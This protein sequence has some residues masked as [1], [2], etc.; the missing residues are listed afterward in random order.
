MPHSFQFQ[1][2]S[3]NTKHS[4]ASKATVANPGQTNRGLDFSVGNGNTKLTHQSEGQG[5]SLPLP[6][7]SGRGNGPV[8]MC[9][10]G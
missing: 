3:S 6:G 9:L 8:G 1:I 2:T 7:L 5:G 4:E 10:S